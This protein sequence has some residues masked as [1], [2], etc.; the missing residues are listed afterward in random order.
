MN[1]NLLFAAIA[2]LVCVTAN[3]MS[4]FSFGDTVRINP[5]RL[6][7]YQKMICTAQLDGYADKWSLTMS[8][9]AG[10]L[11]KLVA[12]ITALEGMAVEYVDNAG[13]V[14]VYDAPL[15]VSEAYNTIASSVPVYGYWDYN[16]DGVLETYGTAKWEPGHYEMFSLNFYI[17]PE[18]RRGWLIIDGTISSS[19]DSRG[20]I[21]QNV[22]FYKK[23]WV[24]VGYQKGDVNGDGR[25]SISDV[26]LLISHLMG[27]AMEELNEFQID[28][29]EFNLDGKVSIVD[30]TAIIDSIMTRN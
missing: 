22:Q 7:G 5:N 19:G 8:Y 13:V 16:E 18:F 28:A 21:L 4:F 17:S 25:V 2:L 24:Y 26:T 29:A 30:V 1:K 10:T 12:G 6:D 20:P 23:T 3:A 9:P 14:Q 27:D 15:Q 11:P